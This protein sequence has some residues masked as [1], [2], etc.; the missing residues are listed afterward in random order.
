MQTQGSLLPENGS[1]DWKDESA[2]QRMLR[3]ESN[4]WKPRE[5]PGTVS[6]SGTAEG[7]NPGDTW[8][9]DIQPPEL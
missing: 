7:T 4:P 5:R 2:S 8:I 1:R 6:S 9:S 3:N